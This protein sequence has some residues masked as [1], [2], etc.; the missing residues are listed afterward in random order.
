MPT[1][2]RPYGYDDD[3]RCPTCRDYRH[4]LAAAE[5]APEECDCGACEDCG[6]AEDEEDTRNGWGDNERPLSRSDREALAAPLDNLLRIGGRYW[7]AEVEVNEVTPTTAAR[8]LGCDREDYSSRSTRDANITACSDCTV[9]AEIKLSRMRDGASHHA[10]MARHAYATLR[11]A[12]A[13]CAHNAGHHVHV[14]AT[15]TVDLGVEAVSNVLRASLTLA[16]ACEA[17]LLP[18]C[19]SGYRYHRSGESDY[20]GSLKESADYAT[21]NR[22]AWHASPARSLARNGWEFG[23][24]PTF[25]FRL[26]NGTTE[27]VRAH[28]YVATALGL[29]DFGERCQQRD[30]DALEFKRLATDKLRHTNGW[31]E[32]DSAAILSRA[33]H[34]SPDSFTALHIAAA[35]SPATT[36]HVDAWRIAAERI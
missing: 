4:A 15:R 17:A 21:R 23:G 5:E 9:D 20:C 26:P 36:Q 2:A 14:D 30:P 12:G 18:L 3:C 35:T 32:A 8:I 11:N 13:T 27:A 7:S 33:L 1:P 28:A 31:S 19:A 34:Y 22:S 24:I 16:S 6:Y 10:E 29:L 25:E